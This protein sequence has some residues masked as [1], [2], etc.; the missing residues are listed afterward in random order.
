MTCPDYPDLLGDDRLHDCDAIFAEV[1]AENAGEQAVDLFHAAV[2]T[3]FMGRV[4]KGEP[5]EPFIMQFLAN[6]FAKVL[7]GAVWDEVIQLPARELPPG[8]GVRSP[9]EERDLRL[10]CEIVS[11][12][13]DGEAVTKAI[14]DV[15]SESAVSYETARAAYYE[16]SKR[17]AGRLS[18]FPAK[19]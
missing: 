11:R 16:W 6:A 12:R 14:A 13:S 5:V 4:N 18:N 10:F 3:R 1:R 8:W 2:L 19:N 15:A 17:F 9:K 7:A